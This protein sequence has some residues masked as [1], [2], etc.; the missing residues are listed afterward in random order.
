MKYILIKDLYSKEL[1]AIFLKYL[2]NSSAQSKQVSIK[3]LNDFI[4][5]L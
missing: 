4:R 5:N 2:K 1:F 3:I